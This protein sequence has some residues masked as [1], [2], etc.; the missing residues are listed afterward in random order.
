MS[1]FFKFVLT[2]TGLLVF[3]NIAMYAFTSIIGGSFLETNLEIQVG[4]NEIIISKP[5]VFAQ[6]NFLVMHGW[7]WQLFSAMFVHVD[8]VHLV[9][10]MLFLLIFG[11]RAEELFSKKVYLA[12]YFTSGLLG[13]VL[14][15]LGGPAM[16]S[17]GASGAIFGLF[18]A[19]VIYLGEAFG[20]SI[21]S[22][23]VYAFFLL[24]LT[25][26]AGVNFLAH[27]GGLAAG[28]LIGYALARKRK[29]YL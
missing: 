22:A 29:L 9:V 14:S 6:V 11:F 18:G 21:T 8:L 3:A 15:L 13:N 24:F 4:D 12:I 10:N 23:L 2:P 17:A 5:A 27:F 28:L 20:R 7:Y 16:V 25:V 1:K 19:N 26:G